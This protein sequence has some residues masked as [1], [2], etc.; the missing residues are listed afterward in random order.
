MEF[1]KHVMEV[2]TDC[3]PQTHQ[4]HG[5]IGCLLANHVQEKAQKLLSK[6]EL[7]KRRNRKIPPLLIFSAYS[8]TTSYSTTC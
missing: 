3:A 7:R 8:F 2:A 1:A 5:K 6:L 4:V